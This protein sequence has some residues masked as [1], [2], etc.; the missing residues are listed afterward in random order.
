MNLVIDYKNA[1]LHDC[2]NKQLIVVKLTLLQRTLTLL[3]MYLVRR[4]HMYEL[5][6]ETGGMH[7]ARVSPLT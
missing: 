3:T 4:G 7:D 1:R 6:S 2:S 5:G